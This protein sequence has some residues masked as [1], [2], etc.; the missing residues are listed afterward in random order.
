[1]IAARSS[2]AAC[3]RT[4]KTVIGKRQ[5]GIELGALQVC[6]VVVQLVDELVGVNAVDSTGL[7]DGLTMGGHAAQAVHTG[8]QED[9]HAALVGSL[10][11]IS[12]MMVFFVTVMR[13]SPL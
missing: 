10:F 2:A 13:V 11:R 3:P 5:A 6:K 9:G 8:G 1:M 12:A 4:Y 7:L